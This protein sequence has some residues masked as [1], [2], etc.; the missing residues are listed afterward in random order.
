M[1]RKRKLRFDLHEHYP[2]EIPTREVA[3]LS[4]NYIGYVDPFPPVSPE[5]GRLPAEC[6]FE[7]ADTSTDY[8]P[9]SKQ[10]SESPPQPPTISI[11]ATMDT[12]TPT[13]GGSNSTRSRESIRDLMDRL[14]RAIAHLPP[15]EAD[16]PPNTAPP[17]YD[18]IA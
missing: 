10:R 9:S 18:H 16:E 6:S 12:Q 7:T 11:Q 15:P 13:P 2:R 8:V 3:D 17:R 14:N 4:R 1:R 5:I